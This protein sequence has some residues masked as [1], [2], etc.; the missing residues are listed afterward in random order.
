MAHGPDMKAEIFL[1]LGCGADSEWMPLE[2]S[3]AG[4][5]Q[6]DVVSRLEIEVRGLANDQTGDLTGQDDSH[7]DPR[8][9]FFRESLAH[10]NTLFDDKEEAGDDEPFPK[11]GRVQ[12]E[13]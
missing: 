3:D 7:C 10:P 2:K 12:N 5:V 1:L 13:K 8:F 6:K 9:A 11:Y 4:N